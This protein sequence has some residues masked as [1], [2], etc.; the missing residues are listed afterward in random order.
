MALI[1]NIL[2]RS[3]F[4]GNT[5]ELFRFVY[6]T[7]VSDQFLYTSAE[8]RID[9]N[10]Q[11]YDPIPIKRGAIRSAGRRSAGSVTVSVPKS[12]AIAQLMQ[13][14]PPRRMIG[15]QIYEGDT[16]EP[17]GPDTYAGDPIMTLVHEG[18]LQEAKH[19]GNETQLICNDSGFGL[20]RPGLRRFYQRT[21]GHVLYGDRCQADQAA[22]TFNLTVTPFPVTGN[23]VW[24]AVNTLTADDR[25]HLVG[26]LLQWTGPQG[27]ES[28]VIVSVGSQFINTDTDI[29]P[30]LLVDDPITLIKGCPRTIDACVNIHNN[31][32]NY[33]GMPYIND[34]DPEDRN[35]HT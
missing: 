4:R 20:R 34:D 23:T 17:T 21:C 12:S 1:K 19:K 16:P 10:G 9:F 8:R 6:G 31:V 15:V 13:G 27:L 35:N 25:E 2:K 28:R 24:C 3:R 5:V 7:G 29:G 26:G 18:T 11:T 30:G 32:Q 22:A 33:G 14:S